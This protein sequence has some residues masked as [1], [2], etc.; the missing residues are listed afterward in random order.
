M[1]S[2]D[3]QS[4]SVVD[5]S[6]TPVTTENQLNSFEGIEASVIDPVSNNLL[7]AISG[8]KWNQIEEL[9]L[10]DGRKV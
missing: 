6:F 10:P 2:T 1:D 3:D 5:T 4:E 8:Y 7:M 9:H